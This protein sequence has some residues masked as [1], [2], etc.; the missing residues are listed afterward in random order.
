MPCSPSVTESRSRVFTATLPVLEPAFLD[1]LHERKK[2]DPLAPVVILAPSNLLAVHLRRRYALRHDGG[3]GFVWLTFRDLAA[4]LAA[5]SPA[6]GAVARPRVPPGGEILL[7]REAARRLPAGSSLGAIRD[8]PGVGAALAATARDLRDGAVPWEELAS[9]DLAGGSLAR[10]RA[11][12][13]AISSVWKMAAVTT[14]DDSAVF[15]DAAAEGAKYSERLGSG[16]LL[17]YG[18]YD[19]TGSQEILIR[20]IAR[21]AR[22]TLFLPLAGAEE[23]PAARI[24]QETGLD[25]FGDRLLASLVRSGFARERFAEPAP[26]LTD[27]DRVRRSL[28]LGDRAEA[29]PTLALD[30]SV[31]IVSAVGESGEAKETAR[32]VLRLLAKGFQPAEIA[33]VVA[34]PERSGALIHEALERGAIPH[35]MSGGESVADTA[36]GKAS[37]RFLQLAQ[38]RRRDRA[39]ELRFRRREVIRFLSA[40]P[41]GPDVAGTSVPGE[42]SR[43]VSIW[44]SLSERAGIVEGLDDWRRHLAEFSSSVLSA[45]ETAA[46]EKLKRVV[47]FLAADLAPPPEGQGFAAGVSRIV[48]AIERWMAPSGDR[49]SVVSSI[50]S[51][52]PLEGFAAS[53]KVA[54]PDWDELLRLAAGAIGNATIPAAARFGRGGVEVLSL[55]AMR[56]LRFRAIVAPGFAQGTFPTPR[57]GDPVLAD[58]ARRRINESLSSRGSAGRLPLKGERPLEE[59]L[60][61]GLLLQS[62]EEEIVL[63]HPRSDA[64]TGR[65]ILPSRLLVE[66]AEALGAADLASTSLVRRAP[67]AFEAAEEE[68]LDRIELLRASGRSSPAALRAHLRQQGG[69]P[70]RALERSDETARDPNRWNRWN[71]RVGGSDEVLRALEERA[72]SGV[73][74]RRGAISP[75]AIETFAVCPRKYFYSKI[76][77]LEKPEEPAEAVVLNAADRGELVHGILQRFVDA[78]IREGKP[79]VAGIA[80]DDP[81]RT[82]LAA[83]LQSIANEELAAAEAR[84][85]VGLPL[86][87]ELVGETVR[88]ELAEWFRRQ[89]DPSEAR[90]IWEEA[91]LPFGES[92][93]RTIPGKERPPLELTFGEKTYRFKGRVDRLDVDRSGVR[94]ALRVVDYKTGRSDRHKNDALAGGARF[95]MPV[96]LEAARREIADPSASGN[97]I[98]DFI[99]DKGE[100]KRIEVRTERLDARRDDIA[101]IVETVDVSVRE[102]FFFPNPSQENCGLCDYRSICL[103]RVVEQEAALRENDPATIRFREMERIE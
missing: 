6:T 1:A 65:T 51:L 44:D 58:A 93:G 89:C 55:A 90:W 83:R 16:E 50:A 32:E 5:P 101:R 7:G 37:L 35:R 34:D 100:W 2:G 19:L 14:G 4:R 69:A 3:A 77:R 85:P 98:Y 91:E 94:A 36:A 82:A 78:R 73:A 15:E 95:Q 57:R 87:W 21:F 17:G 42:I 25:R 30:G 97:G 68:A 26:A 70:A 8:R 45:E 40:A 62:A 46:L 72:P 49:D 86:F 41:L 18:F 60:L 102:G 43:L 38:E 84:L 13:D 29:S 71:G 88:L 53:V 66:C 48:E 61:F 67:L 10:S 59:R 9:G 28:V 39:A 54:A 56:G 103:L 24:A 75:T 92:R 23:D 27:L 79:N 12:I 22:V 64:R 31:R 99:S 11:P 52:G 63:L 47:G 74:R 81:E 80:P 76:L 20:E 96:Y 33:V